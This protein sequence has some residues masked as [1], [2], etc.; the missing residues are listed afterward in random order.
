M[1]IMMAV[2][3]EIGDGGLYDR[4]EFRVPSASRTVPRWE[5]T[6]SRLD[7]KRMVLTDSAA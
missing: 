7:V 3:V 2:V 6:M 1:T 5:I 4:M